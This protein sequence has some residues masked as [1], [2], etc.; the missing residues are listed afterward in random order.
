MRLI[1]Q[2]KSIYIALQ[3]DS[4]YQSKHNNNIRFLVE[5]IHVW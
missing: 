5:N 2:V 1:V 3:A 4:Q